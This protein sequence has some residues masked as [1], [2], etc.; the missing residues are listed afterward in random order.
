MTYSC[1]DFVE[2]IGNTMNMVRARRLSAEECAKLDIEPD[3][4]NE[5]AVSTESALREG[6]QA[7]KHLNDLLATME[8]PR[9]RKATDA[10]QAALTFMGASY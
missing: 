6:L 7:I 3:S 4:L 10:W 5:L 1:S 9:S 2:D 8:T